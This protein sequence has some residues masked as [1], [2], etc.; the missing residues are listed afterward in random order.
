MTTRAMPPRL[1]AARRPMSKGENAM[2]ESFA[3]PAFKRDRAASS[4]L[5]L[6]LERIER[7]RKPRRFPEVTGALP[8]ARPANSG[9]HMPSRP[10]AVRVLGAHVEKHDILG[11]D[12]IALH[13]H[14]FRDVGD[15]A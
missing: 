1:M 10:P 9:R 7:R 11:D 13:A 2:S 8:E 6:L 14:H 3:V 4:R 15:A 12:D 5:C